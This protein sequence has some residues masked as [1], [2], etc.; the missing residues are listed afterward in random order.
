MREVTIDEATVFAKAHS[1][2][3]YHL[4]MFFME[5]STKN[6][7]DI[8]KTFKMML[9]KIL[10]FPKKSET[11]SDQKEEKKTPIESQCTKGK[12]LSSTKKK[13]KSNCQ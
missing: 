2:I 5:V 12:K 10:E 6:S 9:E 4:D 1:I 8:T 11:P 13:K 7:T 3:T